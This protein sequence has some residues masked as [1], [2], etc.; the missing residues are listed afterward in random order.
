MGRMNTANAIPPNHE[1]QTVL[2]IRGMHCAGCVGRVEQALRRVPGVSA[3]AVNLV[4]ERATI[5]ADERG[6]A[7][8][9][10]AAVAAAGYAAEIDPAAAPARD[11]HEANQRRRREETRGWRR[12]FL[13]AAGM[14][15]LLFLSDWFHHRH[16][17][18]VLGFQ[19]L[20]A[21]LIQSV[22][23]GPYLVSAVTQLRR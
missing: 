1:Q 19:L 18:L 14:S 8:A 6:T 13:F 9:F 11:I 7:T 5:V 12:R 16:P 4:L 23:G 21:A 2:A 20:L 22:V 10:M 3:A 17:D 15:A